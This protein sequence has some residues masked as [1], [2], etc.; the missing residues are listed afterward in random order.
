MLCPVAPDAVVHTVCV[1]VNMKQTLKF[2]GQLK[3]AIT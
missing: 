2:Q 1:Q 3:L